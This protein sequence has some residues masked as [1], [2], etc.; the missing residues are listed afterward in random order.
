MPASTQ[1]QP[2]SERR[3][4]DRLAIGQREVPVI[5]KRHLAQRIREVRPERGERLE[6]TRRHVEPV[7]A[8]VEETM[9]ESELVSGDPA[10]RR[11]GTNDAEGAIPHAPAHLGDRPGTDD[12][13][14]AHVAAPCTQGERPP[15][16]I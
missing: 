7:P 14:Q 4:R 11:V 8:A 13:A 9:V 2:G 16:I 5:A 12:A 10:V 15:E 3:A 1:D 6:E